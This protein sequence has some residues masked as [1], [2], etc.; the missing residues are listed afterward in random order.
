SEQKEKTLLRY[1][2]LH[3]QEYLEQTSDN[4]FDNYHPAETYIIPPVKRFVFTGDLVN[5]K[6]SGDNYIVLTPSCDLAHEGKTDNVLLVK[7]ENE[8]I[9]EIAV[10]K[11]IIK[12]NE[13]N[14]KVKEAKNGLK[15]LITNNKNKYHFLPSY[16]NIEGGL[17]NFQV[18]KSVLKESILI[19]YER[20]ASLNSQFTKD[21]VS[22]FSYYYSRQGSPDFD[23]DEI[24]LS[25]I[26]D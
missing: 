17:I 18:L 2:L 3:I 8:N 5:E 9:G 26:K 25:L 24:Y 12:A 22:R 4:T 10:L 1:T 11:D 16:K 21:V 6:L 13:S 7:I 23:S 20:V 19:D 15:R 14:G